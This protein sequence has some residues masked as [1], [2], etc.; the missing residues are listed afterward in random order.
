MQW[1][2][3]PDARGSLAYTTDSEWLTLE[4]GA[5]GVGAFDG[6]PAIH[7]SSAP[8]AATTAPAKADLGAAAGPCRRSLRM[9]R[10]ILQQ[11]SP[12]RQQV[13]KRRSVRERSGR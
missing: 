1:R 8:T 13:P 9:P 10:A 4:G 3:V 11:Y 5:L 12:L 6:T 2:E 7:Q